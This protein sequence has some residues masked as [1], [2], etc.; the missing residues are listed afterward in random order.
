MSEGILVR[1]R[2]RV[3]ERDMVGAKYYTML[4]PPPQFVRQPCTDDE[5]SR[6]QGREGETGQEREVKRWK[7]KTTTE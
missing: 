7:M 1:L 2:V 4:I 5:L 3:K 6:V